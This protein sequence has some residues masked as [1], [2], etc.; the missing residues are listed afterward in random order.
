[1]YEYLNNLE[2][3]IHPEGSFLNTIAAQAALR[4]ETLLPRQLLWIDDDSDFLDL[5]QNA[6]ELSS[7]CE[8]TTIIDP[9]QAGRVASAK[10][11]DLIVVDW[12]M[13]ELN[14]FNALRRVQRQLDFDQLSPETWFERKTPVIVATVH[15][16]MVV[17]KE[18]L[19]QG[20]FQY[21]GVVDKRQALHSI[22]RDISTLYNRNEKNT[23]AINREIRRGPNFFS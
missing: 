14:G 4:L 21:L 5:A 2:L 3:Y 6:I 11:F 22:V 20:C 9:Y 19:P 1:M 23:R 17:E 13:P 7:N 10:A 18:R 8:V 16:K 15:E 12:N